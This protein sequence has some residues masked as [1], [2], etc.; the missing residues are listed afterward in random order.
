MVSDEVMFGMFL[1][2]ILIRQPS[3]VPY[4]IFIPEGIHVMF[5]FFLGTLACIT[6]PFLEEIVGKQLFA[7]LSK[8]KVS[9]SVKIFQF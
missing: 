1:L 9:N 8:H 6:R 7:P 3:P 5:R 2:L 4:L